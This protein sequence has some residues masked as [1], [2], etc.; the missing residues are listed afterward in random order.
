V[1]PEGKL[2]KNLRIVHRYIKAVNMTVNINTVHSVA[3]SVLLNRSI[4]QQIPKLF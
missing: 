2:K 4:P 1:R 3:H